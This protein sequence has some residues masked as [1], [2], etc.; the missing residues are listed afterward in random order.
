ML[1][2]HLYIISS[3]LLTDVG[4]IFMLHITCNIMLRRALRATLGVTFTM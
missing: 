2:T 4:K 3:S 1:Q